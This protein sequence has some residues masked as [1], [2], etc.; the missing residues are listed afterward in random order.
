MN[1][2]TFLKIAGMG[3]LSFASGCLSEP[4][5]SLFSLVQAPDD[6]VTGKSTWYATTCRECPAGC[7]VLAKNREG[8]VVKLEGNPLH[9]VNKGSLCPRGQAALQGVYN[10]DRIG[11]PLV[12]EG[13][14]W[15]VISFEQAESLL[16]EKIGAAA[17]QGP[18]RIRLMSDM[19]GT[20]L[21]RLFEES[22][23]R[24]ESKGVVIFE[25]FAYESLKT[26]NQMIFGMEGLASYRMDEADFL[27]SFGADFLETW[28]SPVMYARQFKKMHA[29]EGGIKKGRF[30]HI[31]PY[32]S[33]TAANADLWLSCRPG[34]EAAVALGLI[35]GFLLKG[36]GSLTEDKAGFLKAL[37]APYTEERVVQI[38]G[39][40]HESYAALKYRLEKADRP[41]V[42]G[43]GSGAS[44]PNALQTDVA[45]NLLNLLLEPDLCQDVLDG[46]VYPC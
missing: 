28:L 12:K 45:A 35:R 32:Q 43:T 44:V 39:V 4:E 8:R 24:W 16:R 42:L 41:L 15:K 26:A 36:T 27:L 6:M 10:P 19:V 23:H 13:E 1:R 21:L 30:V 18:D 37:T 33:L 7:G 22:L 20:P 40:S 11:K 5:K 31:S 29:L 17:R 2:R 3:S 34:G 14:R 38:S 46:G 25:P 9:P